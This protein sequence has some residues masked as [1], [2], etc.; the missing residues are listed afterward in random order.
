M[1][2]ISMLHGS[3][4][5]GT[6]DLIRDLFAREFHN[7]YLSPMNDSAVVPGGADL[8]VTTD[9]FVVK[10]LFFRGGDIGRLAVSGTINDLLTSGA[11]PEYLT[12]AFILEEGL[13]IEELRRIVRSMEQT[14]EEAGVFIVAGDTK[15]VEGSGGLYINTSGVGFVPTGMAV[16][17]REIRKGDAVLVSGTLGDHHA[18]ILSSRMSI[19]NEIE[20]DIAPLNSIVRSIINE[21][22]P[23][24]A[25][26]DVTRGGL[27]TV[28]SEMTEQSGKSVVLEE[29]EIPV[30][31]A[32]RDFC[33]L[34]G[35]DPLY[36]GNE[37]K[38]VIFVPEE[39]AEEA[40]SIMKKSRYGGNAAR[41]G[42]VLTFEEEEEMGLHPDN[43]ELLMR[44][45][46]GGLRHLEPLQGEGLPRIC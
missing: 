42:R 4:G 22:I 45:G 38:M 34:L 39:S 20:S 28:L 10:P 1:S 36:M 6:A 26:R 46:I 15:V 5:T 30:S 8:A 9:S 35:L 17:P 16:S 24:H 14:A 19:E 11:V 41:I 18:A 7:P 27:A 37:G 23:V 12:A 25:M 31:P 21:G 13:E 2:K 44:T 33:G 29:G 32:V 40:L 3:G 43:G